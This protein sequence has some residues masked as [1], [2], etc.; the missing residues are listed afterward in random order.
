MTGRHALVAGATGLVG[1]HLLQRLLAGQ[2][3]SRITA[4]GRTAPDVQ[5]AA[6]RFITCEL[7]DLEQALAGGQWDDAFCCLGT[8]MKKAGSQA[9]FRAVDLDA[10][11]GFARAARAGG[12]RFFGLVSAAGASS[13]SG[14]FY[15][16]TKGQAEAEVQAAG[17]ESAAV[18]R[19]GVLRGDRAESRPA[20]R[21]AILAAPLTDMLMVGA[22]ARYRSVAA[23]EVATAL[24]AAAMEARPGV[25]WLEPQDM[26][27]LAASPA[28]RGEENAK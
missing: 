24:V 12:A 19:P 26:K 14:N 9:A 10:V 2:A 5:H 28:G 6:L 23:D 17:F 1:R 16:R 21:L 27:R 18:A 3:W 15:L 4:V 20:E 7:A 11:A 8:T 25:R 13:A 22:L